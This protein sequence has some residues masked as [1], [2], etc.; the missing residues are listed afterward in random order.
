MTL[1]TGKLIARD[2]RR[3]GLDS[4]D[5][6]LVHSSLSAVGSVPGGEQ[7]VAAAIR[8]VVGS[9]GTIVVPAQSWQ[10]CDPAYLKMAPEATWDQIRDSLPPYDKRWTPTR[11]MGRLAEAIR[12]HPEAVRSDHPHRSFA[13]WGPDAETIVASH[14]LDD[15]VGEGSPLAVLDAMGARVLLLGVSWDKCTALHLGESRS[16]RELARVAN[17]A[18]MVVDGKRRWVE[19]TEPAVDDSDF[20]AVGAA[21]EADQPDSVKRERVGN[22]EGRLV[23]MPALVAFAAKWMAEHR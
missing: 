21:C 3:L 18:P 11:T 17:G 2:L 7:A 8:T 15:P 22:A 19:F 10:L 12:T 1:A 14:A 4:G 9:G 23:D 5:T 16:G 6:V 20:F 13:A